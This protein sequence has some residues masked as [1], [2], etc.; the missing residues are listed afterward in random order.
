ML[1]PVRVGAAPLT[2][3]AEDASE[4]FSRADGTGYANDI[5]RAAFKAAH[6]NVR[7][8]I[9]PYARCKK[10][11]ESGD[12]PACFAMSWAPDI[13]GV[14][15]FSDQPIYEVYADIFRNRR[16]ASVITGIQ[17]LR[18]GMVVGVVN[19]YEY[20]DAV[21]RLADHGIVLE[22]GIN[23]LGILKMLA[24]RR[25]D[26]AVVMTSDF[27]SPS[28]RLTAAGVTREVGFAFRS[29]V[30]KSYVGFSV[31]N[32]DGERARQAFNAGYRVIIQNHTRDMIRDA[33]LKASA[34]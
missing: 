22:R 27:S 15:K 2:I 19:G 28:Q 4:P 17:D 31:R 21:D 10:S 18:P 24:S 23:E 8:D 11:L 1:S 6:V 34:P 32:P 30:L 26:A 3:M 16:S 33:W 20:P 12:T 29:G 9:V 13:K 14:V 7:L 5:V 25:L